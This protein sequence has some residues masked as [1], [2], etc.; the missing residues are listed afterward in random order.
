M[1]LHVRSSVRCPLLCTLHWPSYYLQEV[2]SG[3]LQ[4]GSLC[5]YSNCSPFLMPTLLSPS[6]H[7][8]R[9]FTKSYHRANYI[10]LR[11]FDTGTLNKIVKEAY[12][13]VWLKRFYWSCCVHSA[14][15]YDRPKVTFTR[16]LIYGTAAEVRFCL[17]LIIVWNCTWR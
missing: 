16:V 10:P 8:T 17:Y 14:P 3:N 12:C 13:T 4:I 15:V 2:S 5:S 9:I 7:N 1:T 6:L 11:N